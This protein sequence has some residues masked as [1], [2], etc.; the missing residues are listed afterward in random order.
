MF[1][2][3]KS[4]P[5]LSEADLTFQV[6]TYAWLLKHFGGDDF[7]KTTQLVLPTSSFFPEQVS[8]PKQAAL[9]TFESVKQHAGMATWQCQ[10]V[11]QDD[12]INPIV[13]PTMVV[14]NAPVQ[15]NGT[16]QATEDNNVVITYK[17]SLIGQPIQLV[18]TLAHELS[19]YLT[20]TAQ[21]PPP[22]GWENWEFAT[23]ITA[24]FLGFGIFMANSAF[25]FRQYSNAESQG[26]QSN[27]SGYLSEQEHIYA[28]A[29]FLKLKQLPIS[30]ALV[31]LKPHLRKFLKK[32]DKELDKSGYIA[33]LSEV[34]YQPNQTDTDSAYEH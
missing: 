6:A 21:E 2:L 16:F 25:N 32:A 18:A 22:G 17:P 27:T 13:S 31:H 26:W 34:V 1:Q 24:T 29:I 15:P 30:Y 7:Y 5:L 10:L 12:D 3:F 11:A 33:E 23:D 4:E 20:A 19:H 28:L 9:A 8:E 14:Q